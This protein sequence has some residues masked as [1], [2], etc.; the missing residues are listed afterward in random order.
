MIVRDYRGFGDD[1]WTSI[2]KIF[3][4]PL[5]AIATGWTTANAK[6][7]AIAQAQAA[8]NAALAQ[9]QVQLAQAQAEKT[10]EIVKYV[11]FGGAAII[12]LAVVGKL[13]L[14]RRAK[15]AV[16]GYRRRR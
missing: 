4:A 16:A 1:T 6:D 15:P 9:S 8:S 3:T 7:A 2:S 12:G 14:A 10:Q 11:A 13:V 5:D